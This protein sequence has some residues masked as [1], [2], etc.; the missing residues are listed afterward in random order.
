LSYKTPPKPAS[1]AEETVVKENTQQY[2][3]WEGTLFQQTA[4]P[5]LG[6]FIYLKLLT[7]AL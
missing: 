2:M 6:T 5:Y 7:Q 4:T 1:K 3:H